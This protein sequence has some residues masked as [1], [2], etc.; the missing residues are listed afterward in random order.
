MIQPTTVQVGVF[1]TARAFRHCRPRSRILTAAVH[2]PPIYIQPPAAKPACTRSRPSPATSLPPPTLRKAP[3][4]RVHGLRQLGSAEPLHPRAEHRHASKWLA[5]PITAA[6]AT[7]KLFGIRKCPNLH[8]DHGDR[9]RG[10]RVIRRL[11]HRRVRAAGANPV[12][13]WCARTRDYQEL[14]RPLGYVAVRGRCELDLAAVLF[15]LACIRGERLITTRRPGADRPSGMTGRSRRFH[16]TWHVL[17]LIDHCPA[18]RRSR[19]RCTALSLPGTR[20]SARG[21]DVRVFGFRVVGI[22]LTLRGIAD[23][24]SGPHLRNRPRRRGL[25]SA[26]ENLHYV[27]DPG[28]PLYCRHKWCSAACPPANPFSDGCALITVLLFA[29][30]S[31]AGPRR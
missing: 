24:R 7:P 1:P 6:L 21:R 16:R 19:R 17:R 12:Q 5:G 14:R 18:S 30:V 20:P 31:S 23:L 26:H 11:G 8:A 27:C 13:S 25:I 29:Q 10:R 3:S 28:S 2:T 22:L 9:P 4:S 15:D